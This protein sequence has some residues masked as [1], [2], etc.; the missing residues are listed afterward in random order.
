MFLKKCSN[1]ELSTTLIKVEVHFYRCLWLPGGAQTARKETVTKNNVKSCQIDVRCS[2]T[3]TA[4]IILKPGLLFSL[5]LM[6]EWWC[7]LQ[8][9]RVIKRHWA[10]LTIVLKCIAESLY[11]D[12]IAIVGQRIVDSIVSAGLLFVAEEYFHIGILQPLPQ[13]RILK[14]FSHH[15]S[16]HRLHLSL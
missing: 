6:I 15:L 10:D 8:S 11:R 1:S 5:D 13:Q 4:P 3:M 12:I 16:T 7:P 14:L 2:F 9:A